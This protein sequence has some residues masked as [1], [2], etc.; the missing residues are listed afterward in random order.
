[1][2][3]MGNMGTNEE[4]DDSEEGSAESSCI[5]LQGSGRLADVWRSLWPQR[6]TVEFDPVR[7]SALL[8]EEI[9]YPPDAIGV[10]QLREILAHGQLA[11]HDISSSSS[12]LKRLCR[13]HLRNDETLDTAAE[14]QREYKRAKRQKSL[15]RIAVQ[16]SMLAVAVLATIFS[17]LDWL[18][19]ARAVSIALPAV[20]VLLGQID[21]SMKLSEGERALAR[22]AGAVESLLFRFDTLR[23]FPRAALSYILTRAA[24]LF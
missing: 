8:E 20:L 23:P 13:L 2:G 16:G 14:R 3:M 7:V 15:P 1:M 10:A 24:M 18:P 12:T 22:A 9:G 17:V 11:L 4:E 6:A 21:V 5:V 19:A